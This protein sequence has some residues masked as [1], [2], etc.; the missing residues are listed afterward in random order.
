MRAME[1]DRIDNNG[2]YAKG[3][4][5]FVTRAQNN[6]NKRNTVLSKFSQAYWPYER[7]VVIRKLSAGMTRDEIIQDAEKAVFERRK[8][9]RIIGARLDFMIYEMPETI[10]VLP[11]RAS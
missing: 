5:H 2:D 11:Y 7:S 10:T 1:L 9:W 4:I 8:N 6:A 3:N